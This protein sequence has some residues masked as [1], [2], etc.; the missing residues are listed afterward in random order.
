MLKSLDQLINVVVDSEETIAKSWDKDQL[1]KAKFTDGILSYLDLGT[2]IEVYIHPNE[3]LKD[4][5][6][7]P[8]RYSVYP[9]R[10][11]KPATYG[12]LITAAENREYDELNK[13]EISAINRK[14][15]TDPEDPDISV[16]DNFI[17]WI[18]SGLK[19]IGYH[20]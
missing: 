8:K 20:S 5:E 10:A 2:E 16:H 1:A 7:D 11:A 19:A 12:S 13:G 6:D 14:Y 4:K 15:R 3:V 17:A 9:I 18:K